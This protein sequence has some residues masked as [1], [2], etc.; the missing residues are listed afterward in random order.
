[1]AACVSASPSA[2]SSS[3]SSIGSSERALVVAALKRGSAIS[4][5]LSSLA[6]SSSTSCFVRFT[7]LESAN[8]SNSTPARSALSARLILSLAVSFFPISEVDR[9]S[10]SVS[11][12]ALFA[13]N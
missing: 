8:S 9:M 4:S 12:F 7:S 10:D 2:S 3:L 6:Y 11:S 5:S 1:M 13:S